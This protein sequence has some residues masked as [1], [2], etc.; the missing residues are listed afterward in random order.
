LNYENHQ[1]TAKI[2]QFPTRVRENIERRRL[3][4]AAG[5]AYYLG[6]SVVPTYSGAWYH[7]AAI[8]DDERKR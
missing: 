1:T 4:L 5:S 2:Y 6:G 7:D 8:K 3:A